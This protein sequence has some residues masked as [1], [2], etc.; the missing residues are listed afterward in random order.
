M[1]GYYDTDKTQA[2]TLDYLL[3][4]CHISNERLPEISNYIL[5]EKGAKRKLN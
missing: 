5:D 3:E 1:E 4:H 2:E